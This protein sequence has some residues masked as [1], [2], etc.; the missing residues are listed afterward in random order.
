MKIYGWTWVIVMA[1]SLIAAIAFVIHTSHHD[2]ARDP[3]NLTKIVK[4]DLPAIAES[5]SE[6][7][8]SRE[9]SR[10]DMYIH[11]GSFSEELSAATTKEM[12]ELCVTDSSHWRKN[13]HNG[14]YQYSDQ[15]GIDELYF[16]RCS[17]YKD[18]FVI[19]YEVDESEGIFLLFPFVIVYTILLY[20]GLVLVIILI[21]KRF[22]KR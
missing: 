2:L 8:L 10:W 1:S 16:V 7:N 5:K 13:V 22:I 20:W 15:G 6:N 21:I 3:N 12:D 4:V 17:I 9:A 11:H 19:T 18:R 14:C